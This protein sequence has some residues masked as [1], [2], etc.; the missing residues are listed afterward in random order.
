V[1][2]DILLSDGPLKGVITTD[3]E[4][5]IHAFD[6]AVKRELS[7]GIIVEYLEADDQNDNNK[8]LEKDIDMLCALLSKWTD[9]DTKQLHNR[10]EE[11]Y[12]QNNP[13]EKTEPEAINDS[14]A[15]I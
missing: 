9:E 15:Q 2:T 13:S 1:D 14:N 8:L 10:I 6:K 12:R 5:D 3:K 7:N 11:F 4:V